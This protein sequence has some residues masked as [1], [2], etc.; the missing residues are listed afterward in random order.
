MCKL[1][2]C[3]KPWILVFDTPRLLT[4]YK[5]YDRIPQFSK[6]IVRKFIL[7]HNCRRILPFSEIARKE[8][9]KYFDVPRDMVEVLPPG[10][11]VPKLSSIVRNK[12]KDVVILFV[13]RNFR[14]KGGFLLLKAF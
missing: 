2:R 11:E 9:E 4:I 3:R 5:T 1:Y 8:L 14:R 12:H 13:G 6:T 7:S 10:I